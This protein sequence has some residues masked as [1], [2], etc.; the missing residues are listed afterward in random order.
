MADGIVTSKIPESSTEL[1]SNRSLTG[2]TGLPLSW[3]PLASGRAWRIFQT[4]YPRRR[5]RCSL[6][7]FLLGSVSRW[8]LPRHC[9]SLGTGKRG[10]KRGTLLSLPII[11]YMLASIVCL[12]KKKKT[13]CPTPYSFVQRI[14]SYQQ[15]SQW[16]R[17]AVIKDYRNKHNLF[18]KKSSDF[19]SA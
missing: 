14:F 3:P 4:S 5:K 16:W 6:P 9:F 11:I 17:H 2:L 7:T 18:T 19:K 10:R 1:S 15:D 13:F 8:C 12:F